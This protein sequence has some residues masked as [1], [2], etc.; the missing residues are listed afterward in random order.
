MAMTRIFQV[1][2]L[3]RNVDPKAAIEVRSEAHVML[4]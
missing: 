4:P 2:F 3:E 1:N